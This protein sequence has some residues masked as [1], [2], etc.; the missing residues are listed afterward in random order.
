MGTGRLGR[1]L[2]PKEGK[3]DS[4][5]L[6]RPFLFLSPSRFQTL[7]Y[8]SWWLSGGDPGSGAETLADSSGGPSGTSGA[9]AGGHPHP[10]PGGQGSTELG[11]WGA[12]CADLSPLQPV[13]T[14]IPGGGRPC[15]LFSLVPPPNLSETF[16]NKILFVPPPHPP[17][18]NAAVDCRRAVPYGA[19]GGEGV[20]EGGEGLPA[21][22][23]WSFREQF[24]GG[25]RFSGQFRPSL[26]PEPEDWGAG[27][28][29]GGGGRSRGLPAYFPEAPRAE[30]EG[31]QV[32]GR[33]RGGRVWRRGSG[34][35]PYPP[36]L[37]NWERDRKRVE[38]A[39]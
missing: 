28:G 6:G 8:V 2:T 1:K 35:Q 17:H 10:S 13:K 25:L 23:R 7:F 39:L 34:G 12:L 11:V 33:G 20:A 19:Q 15:F 14:R 31:R 18:H 29:D 22:G 38:P 16:E 21:G 3:G 24:A 30:G 5:L 9:R 27:C 26:D 36:L 32:G 37:A 4:G